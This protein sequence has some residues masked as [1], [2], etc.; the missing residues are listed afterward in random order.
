MKEDPLP[1]SPE[2]LS[3]NDK[4]FRAKHLLNQARD[5]A[6]SIVWED[7]PGACCNGH[8]LLSWLEEDYEYA[9]RKLGM[10]R[11]AEGIYLQKL[12]RIFD[13]YTEVNPPSVTGQQN[14][15]LMQ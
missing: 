11:Q 14:T 15:L 4:R 10:T 2:E 8:M 9:I 13:Q 5:E 3:E 1:P 7:D 12:H 6:L